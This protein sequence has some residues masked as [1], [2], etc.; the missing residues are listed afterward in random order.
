VRDWRKDSRFC[1][2]ATASWVGPSSSLHKQKFDQQD[3]QLQDNRTK[4]LAAIRALGGFIDLVSPSKRKSAVK[5][6]DLSS[7]ALAPQ[8]MPNGMKFDAN[9]ESTYEESEQDEPSAAAVEDDSAFDSASSEKDEDETDAAATKV[10]K[11]APCVNAD[12]ADDGP[13]S[14]DESPSEEDSE[15]DS[16]D[17]ESSSEEDDD[18]DDDDTEVIMSNLARSGVMPATVLKRKRKPKPK[19]KAPA[20]AAQDSDRDED[21]S[22]NDDAEE[23]EDDDDAAAAT[24]ATDG[25]DDVEDDQESD[26]EVEEAPAVSEIKKKHRSNGTKSIVKPDPAAESK[27]SNKRTRDVANLEEYDAAEGGSTTNTRDGSDHGSHR[28]AKLESTKHR[29]DADGHSD[30]DNAAVTAHATSDEVSII[31][32][33]VGKRNKKD[34]LRKV[35]K[36]IVIAEDAAADQIAASTEAE[37]HQTQVRNARQGKAVDRAPV[38]QEHRENVNSGSSFEVNG[39]EDQGMTFKRGQDNFNFSLNKK[40]Y[41]R[42][43]KRGSLATATHAASESSNIANQLNNN[44]QFNNKRK[45]DHEFSTQAFKKKG[46]PFNAGQSSKGQPRAPT[47][48]RNDARPS[49]IGH[50]GKHGG[51]AHFDGKEHRNNQSHWNGSGHAHRPR[52]QPLSRVS[53][54]NG[55]NRNNAAQ[56]NSYTQHDHYPQH[57]SY[58]QQ[59]GSGRQN[60]FDHSDGYNVH[61][62]QRMGLAHVLRDPEFK[63]LLAIE[64]ANLKI[65]PRRR[66]R[67]KRSSLHAARLVSN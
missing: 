51:A 6:A 4:D 27:R 41:E 8:P 32:E 21:A 42:G 25:D 40:G 20:A 15:E 35:T 62:L 2:A 36:Q 16:S 7:A 58:R 56:H 47:L 65:R 45:A 67:P 43:G 50:N 54:N 14:S 37:A 23:D 24:A 59:N 29:D 39:S 13:S 31:S 33:S 12:S 44:Q 53:G 52:R 48:H 63:H 18:D 66:A 26:S 49:N 10:P 30:F 28:K 3:A 19:S 9:I 1:R 46:K 34:K 57:H 22:C 17:R 5:P 11:L 38:L 64:V 61:N 55:F 60:V